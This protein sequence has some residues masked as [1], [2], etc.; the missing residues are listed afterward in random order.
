[1]FS[2]IVILLSVYAYSR[3]FLDGRKGL[4]SGVLWMVVLF[5]LGYRTF[6][7]WEET[8]YGIVKIF[9]VH[10]ID[11]MLIFLFFKAISITKNASIPIWLIAI[12][13][14][15]LIS[16]MIGIYAKY[17]PDVEVLFDFK[18]FF[19][20]V[21]VFLV[22]GVYLKDDR[23]LLEAAYYYILVITA[24]SFFG[25]V[26]VQFPS[27]RS[28]LAGFYN[29]YEYEEY[30]I[31]DGFERAWFS[32]WG[33]VTVGHIIVCAFPLI[34]YVR[35]KIGL[36]KKPAFFYFS[37]VVNIWALYIAGNRADWI[38]TFLIFFLYFF[39]YK[40]IH[41]GANKLILGILSAVLVAFIAIQ[42]ISDEAIQRFIS[43]LI[44]IEGE[45]DYAKDSSGF[46]RQERMGIAWE[47]IFAK[48]FGVGWGVS[49]WVHS[50]FVQIAS[51]GGWILGILYA[52]AFLYT[53]LNGYNI[54]TKNG[55]ERNEKDGLVILLIS[56]L[57]VAYMF[58]I[59]NNYILT[60]SGVPLF[61]L[62][63]LLHYYTVLIRKRLRTRFI[64]AQIKLNEQEKTEHIAA[65]L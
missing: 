13:P 34:Y 1:M 27:V 5:F 35:D 30:A 16:L 41:L 8:V 15:S 7:I 50:D 39:W 60:Q 43:G 58:V 28:A 38:I 54:S 18:N 61:F 11:F 29:D 32:H 14:M 46:K 44:A 2:L 52:A 42:F 64:S 51:N 62:W 24:L 48:P 23:N 37:L 26:E 63:A 3:I 9:K 53:F 12:I 40:K 36:L 45:A 56:N 21:P 65:N 47:T 33:S 25:V 4:E 20:I 6:A 17:P 55:L 19:L 49:G 59:N 57:C 10:P 22:T 31:K